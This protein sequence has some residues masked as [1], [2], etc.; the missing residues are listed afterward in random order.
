MKILRE[1][2]NKPV[3]KRDNHQC[4]CLPEATPNTCKYYKTTNNKIRFIFLHTV[5]L[6]AL[7]S[8]STSKYPSCAQSFI[9]RT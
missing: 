2:R 5:Y 7:G 4:C 3:D 8:I 1:P 9:S 6:Y